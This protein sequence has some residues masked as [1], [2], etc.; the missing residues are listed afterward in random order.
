MLSREKRVHD[1]RADKSSAASYHYPCHILFL[2]EPRAPENRS[3]ETTSSTK[4]KIYQG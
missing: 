3:G 2:H 4:S 1:V